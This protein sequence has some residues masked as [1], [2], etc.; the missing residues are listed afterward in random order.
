MSLWE[1]GSSVS[2]MQ[3]SLAWPSVSVGTIPSPDP[4]CSFSL[5]SQSTGPP[6]RAALLCPWLSVAV[7]TFELLSV[8]SPRLECSLLSFYF[9]KSH[10]TFEAQLNSHVLSPELMG[11]FFAYCGDRAPGQPTEERGSG[12]GL[13]V[14]LGLE[15]PPSLHFFLCKNGNNNCT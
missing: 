1:K 9:S 13:P 14:G 3:P 6:Q 12:A 8:F 4:F 5:W 2:H 10:P 15:L 11:H 7:R